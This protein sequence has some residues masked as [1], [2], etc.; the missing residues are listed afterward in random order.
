MNEKEKHLRARLDTHIGINNFLSKDLTEARH[1]INVY[2]YFKCDTCKE[3]VKGQHI[4]RYEVCRN[5]PDH[6]NELL[7]WRQYDE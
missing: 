6:D 1:I 4:D 7:L 3:W 5:C 2:A